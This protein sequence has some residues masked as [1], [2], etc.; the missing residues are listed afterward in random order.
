MSDKQPPVI[1]EGA[2]DPDDE[3][4]PTAKS[5]E[6]RKAATALA[7]LDGTAEED[8]T[9]AKEVDHEAV[10]KAMKSLAGGAAKQ[11]ATK[12]EVKNVKVDQADVA[13]LVGLGGFQRY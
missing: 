6:D 7:K 3:V 10:S 4:Q 5:A 2:A 8:A 13:L 12:K 9:P 1:A 11:P